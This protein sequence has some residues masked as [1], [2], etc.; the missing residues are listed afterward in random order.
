MNELGSVTTWL[1]RLKAGERREE[2]VERLWHRYFADL[3]TKARGH[4]RAQSRAI[5]GEDVAL[6]VFDRLV[7]AVAAGRFPQ[8][9]NRNDLWQVLL[10]LTARKAKNVKRNEGRLKRGGG[11][12]IHSLHASDSDEK[13][14]QLAGMDPD[15]AE[16]AA[17]AEGLERLLDGLGDV[18]LRNVAIWALEG[19]TNE[20]I[21]E[22]LGRSVAT[23]ERKRKLIREK[24]AEQEN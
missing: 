16:A 7:L 1:E 23:A 5:D 2:A 21:A 22:K 18:Q 4:L 20:E 12:A 14:I 19:H 11:Q 17:L 3:V 8:L 6:S 24:W 13:G 9:D 10:V 15:P